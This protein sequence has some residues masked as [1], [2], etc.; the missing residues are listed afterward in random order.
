MEITGI[1]LSKEVQEIAL[2]SS[3]KQVSQVELKSQ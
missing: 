3:L 1:H 2:S